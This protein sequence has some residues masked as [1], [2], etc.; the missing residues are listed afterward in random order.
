MIGTGDHAR[1][2]MSLDKLMRAVLA[3]IVEGADPAITAHDSEQRLPSLFK[4]KIVTGLV[5]LRGMSSELP[6]C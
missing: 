2:S 6:A 4:G 1:I 5:K 3:H